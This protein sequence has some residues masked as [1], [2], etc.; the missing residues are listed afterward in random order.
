M[1]D[2]HAR[3]GRLALF[4]LV[5][6]LDG[7]IN[8][9]RNSIQYGGQLPNSVQHFP[10]HTRYTDLTRIR[11]N[12]CAFKGVIIGSNPLEFNFQGVKIGGHAQDFT[13]R[14]ETEQPEIARSGSGRYP[15][16][17]LQSPYRAGLY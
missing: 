3:G 13:R 8:E 5:S 9:R 11:P 6:D 7:K 12:N 10:A 4:A 2:E 14:G 17:A 15:G 16:E 1:C